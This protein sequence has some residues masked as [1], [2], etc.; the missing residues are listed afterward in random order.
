M[1]FQLPQLLLPRSPSKVMAKEWY[2]PH[3]DLQVF[4]WKASFSDSYTKF[5]VR[6]C[7]LDNSIINYGCFPNLASCNP[8]NLIRHARKR[9]ALWSNVCVMRSEM[10]FFFFLMQDLSEPLKCSCASGNSAIISQTYYKISSE[11]L[12]YARHGSVRGT[13]KRGEMKK[14]YLLLPTD[15]EEGDFKYGIPLMLPELCACM[16]SC[17][18]RICSL[19]PHGL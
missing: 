3:Q 1:S 5:K 19:P 4:A 6:W 12:L 2:S 13:R 18:S 14:V 15:V 7:H 17:F 11:C 16:L 9:G 10:R 8:G